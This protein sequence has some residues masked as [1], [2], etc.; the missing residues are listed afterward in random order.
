MI[1]SRRK[2]DRVERDLPVL[3]VAEEKR[4]GSAGVFPLH[5][6]DRDRR[7]AER[8]FFGI[9]QPP[10]VPLVKGDGRYEEKREKYSAV[11]LPSFI[12]REAILD[13]SSR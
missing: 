8:M 7:A 9:E 4:G 10:V 3:A 13:E 6:E 11:D 2:L 1:R 5:V 12:S